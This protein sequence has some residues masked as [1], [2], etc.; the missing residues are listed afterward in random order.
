M[1]SKSWAS[2]WTPGTELAQ[3]DPPV[4]LVSDGS[5]PAGA[6]S[7]YHTLGLVPASVLRALSSPEALSRDTTLAGSWKSPGMMASVGHTTAQAGASPTSVRWAQK[8]HFWAVPLSGW[9]YR[10]S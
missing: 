5:R 8:W 10:A 4:V 7:R 1:A 3:I 6:A 2:A 9:M